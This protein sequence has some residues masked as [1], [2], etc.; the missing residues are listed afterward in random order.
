MQKNSKIKIQALPE[1]YT[2][3]KDKF[4]ICSNLSL[5]GVPSCEGVFP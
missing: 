5:I 4:L 3:H 1:T 2:L